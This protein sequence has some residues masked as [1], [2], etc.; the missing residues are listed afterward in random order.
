MENALTCRP[1]DAR[2][3][4]EYQQLLKNMNCP[5][6]E[7]LAVYDKYPLLLSQRDDCYLDK[8]TLICQTGDFRTAI[9][10][11]AS[12]RFHIY[13]GGEGKL[14]KLHAWM[15][16]LYA[17]EL[18]AA[19]QYEQAEKLYR[20]GSDMPKSYGEAKTFFNQEAHIF[21]FL[22]RLYARQGNAAQAQAAFEEATVYKAAVSE[23]SLFRALAL[24][25][26]GQEQDANTV[27]EEMLTAAD[28]LITDKDLRTYYG[29]GSP[30]PMPFEN[31]IEKNNLT[32][33]YVLKAFALL[34]HGK[35]EEAELAANEARRW[36][37]HDFRIFA[38]DKIKDLVS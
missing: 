35:K 32:D 19:G 34:G 4:L 31:H 11:A 23:I 15:H 21:Y 30:S 25:T 24:K 5:I 22:G 3:L 36:N 2:L 14:T 18:A 20:R 16:T 26:L 13:E 9:D 7:R 1:E 29:V 8:L 33:G 37:P 27:L 12:K 28:K 17:N 38:F 6:A 10:M